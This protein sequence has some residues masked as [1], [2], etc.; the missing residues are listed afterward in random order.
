MNAKFERVTNE[1]GFVCGEGVA[2]TTVDVFTGTSSPRNVFQT[3]LALSEIFGSTKIDIQTETHEMG[4][5]P[6]CASSW[7]EIVFVVREAVL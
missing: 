7:E 1:L 3:M 4:F 6:T 5:C 2:A